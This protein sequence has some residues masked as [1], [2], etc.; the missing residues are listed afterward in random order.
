MRL[1][2]ML[3]KIGLVHREEVTIQCLAPGDHFVISR[4][5]TRFYNRDTRPEDWQMISLIGVH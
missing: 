5:D 2:A 4:V 3:L 1:R